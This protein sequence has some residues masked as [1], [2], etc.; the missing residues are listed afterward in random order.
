MVVT[1]KTASATLSQR[2]FLD[3][4]QDDRRAELAAFC[5]PHADLFLKTYDGVR[6]MAVDK[7]SGT[8]VKFKLFR[9]NDFSGAA[10]FLGPVWFFYRKM[11][12]Y[13]W[14]LV[15]LYTVLAFLPSGFG[16]RF[17]MPLA[18]ATG[19][20]ARSG[21]VIWATIKTELMRRPDG[22]LDPAAIAR[23]GGVSKRGLDFRSDLWGGLRGYNR[24]TDLRGQD[25]RAGSAMKIEQ[26]T[27]LKFVA[28]LLHLNA[29]GLG[30]RLR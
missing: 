12:A 5:G 21:Y 7:A 20:F 17:A 19:L 28:S 1:T 26:Y 2:F 9:N 6:Q 29:G 27:E 16:S 25:R 10:F 22:A 8:G 14:G 11:W 3:K 23:V 18:L 15:A 4:D 24:G 30:V 13:A